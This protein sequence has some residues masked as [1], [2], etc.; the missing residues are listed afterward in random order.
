MTTEASP[1]LSANGSAGCETHIGSTKRTRIEVELDGITG[2]VT[3][4]SEKPR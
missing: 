2:A 1:R 3:E 4:I